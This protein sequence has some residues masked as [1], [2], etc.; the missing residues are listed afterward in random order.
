VRSLAIV[1]S[2]LG[3]GLGF[4]LQN[5]ANNFVSGLVLNIGRPIQPGDFV[6]VGTFSGTV[7][8]IG[9]RSTEILTSDEVAIVVPNSRFLEQEVVNWS[10]GDPYCRVHVPV[11]IV[12]GSDLSAARRALLAAA[13]G[14]PAVLR[15]PR[16]SVALR[17]FGASALEL[18]LL[19]WTSDPRRQDELKSDLHFL[20]HAALREHGVELAYA[21]QRLH[22]C[23][24]CAAHAAEPAPI[25]PVAAALERERGRPEFWSDAELDAVA[26]RLRG[27]EGVEIRDR[28]HRLTAYASCFVGREAVDWLVGREGLSRAE[29]V[30]V[31]ERL[32]E[33]GAIRHVVDERDFKDGHF[34]YRF[35]N[36]ELRSGISLRG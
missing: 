10:H 6:V 5:I 20:I 4:G 28:R 12:Y 13:A 14:H 34:F 7:R 11:G 23:T 21:D 1:A 17:A 35:R 2:V 15:D 25:V 24:S 9:P 26:D 22:V 36:G 29:A 27:A 16:P 33:R 18:E 8:R 30:V 3:V 31:G 32:L 19:V